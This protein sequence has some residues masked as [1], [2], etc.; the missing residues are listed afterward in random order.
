MGINSREAGIPVSRA[1]RI[2]TGMNTITTAVLLS[3][4]SSSG[5][6]AIV[7]DVFGNTET[8]RVRF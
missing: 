7:D 4:E 8:L 6:E 1:I 5:V 3:G 2:N